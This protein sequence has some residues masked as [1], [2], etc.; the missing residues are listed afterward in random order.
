MIVLLL[1]QQMEMR[2]FWV[3]AQQEA[4]EAALAGRAG[5]FSEDSDCRSGAFKRVGA[6]Q[7]KEK[8]RSGVS[9]AKIVP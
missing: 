8:Q 5:I 3:P 7:Q 6:S 4:C 2:R 1:I 9:M